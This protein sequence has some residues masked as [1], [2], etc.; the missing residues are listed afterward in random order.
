M[1]AKDYDLK[2]DI[3]KVGHHGSNSST[4]ESFLTAV[5]PSHAVISV[6]REMTTVILMKRY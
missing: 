1:L 3:L 2:A 6:G 4:T 5:K